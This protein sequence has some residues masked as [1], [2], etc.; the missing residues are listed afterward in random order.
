[1]VRSGFRNFEGGDFSFPSKQI[2]MPKRV[3]LLIG[4]LAIAAALYA[5]QA[6]IEKVELSGIVEDRLSA[7][8]RDALRRLEGQPYDSQSADQIAQ[9]I[10]SELPDYVATPTTAPGAQPNRVRLIYSVAHNINSRYLVEA[11]ELRA[12]DRS[13]VSGALWEEMQKMVG[14]PVNDA[15]ADRLKDRLVM[16][17][18]KSDLHVTRSVIRGDQPQHVKIIYQG[19]STNSFSFSFGSGSYHSKQKF[20][21]KLTLGYSRF[22][23][24]G[25]AADLMNNSN[26]LMERYA[27]YRGGIWAE[28]KRVRFSVNYSSLRAQWSPATQQAAGNGASSPLYRLRDTIEPSAKITISPAV[29][30]TLGVAATQLQMQSPTLHFISTLRAIGNIEYRHSSK[31]QKNVFDGNYELHVAGHT[32]GG[33]AVYTRNLLNQNYKFSPNPASKVPLGATNGLAVSFELGRI[34]G[35]APM[36]DRFSLGNVDTLLG[37]N[38]YDIS[39]LGASRMAYG[40][41]GYLTKYLSVWFETGSVWDPD[42]PRVL[43]KSVSLRVPLGTALH[44]NGPARIVLDVVSPSMGIPIRGSH[45][46]P[47]FAIGGGN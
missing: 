20:S 43:R 14:H 17:F 36:F 30:L 26:E 15:V 9:R 21:G 24:I 31:S 2:H 44:L 13:K 40:S 10:Q 16:E 7:N 35:N 47:M 3:I 34:S 25:V 37:W 42:Q 6:T 41:V 18:K 19:H 46:N 45:A 11:V 29:H 32:L 38:K 33:D 28:Q 23:V 4:F 39:P 1:M 22:D 12:I 5:Q 27:G 8:L